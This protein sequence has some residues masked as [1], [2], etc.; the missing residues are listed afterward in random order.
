MIITL[1]FLYRVVSNLVLTDSALL[2]VPLPPD[3]DVALT[4]P[5]SR[6]DCVSNVTR[7]LINIIYLSCMYLS[8]EW[9]T[10]GTD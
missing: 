3:S 9:K 1:H 4:V 10:T 7:W 8:W 2:A 5:K 6:C